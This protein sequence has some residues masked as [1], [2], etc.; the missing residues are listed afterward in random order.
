MS[1]KQQIVD[2]V[3][4][5]LAKGT[6]VDIHLAAFIGDVKKVESFLEEGVDV[7]TKAK[8]GQTPLCLAA[9]SGQ[10]EMIRFL[11]G[12]GADVNVKAW[13]SSTEEAQGYSPLYFALTYPD[14]EVVKMLID[15]G[16][17]IKDKGPPFIESPLWMLL[18]SAM[19]RGAKVF[20]EDP[21]L[22]DIGFSDE[23]FELYKETLD[24]RTVEL[25]RRIW[26]NLRDVIKLLL[27]RGADV[28]V[29]G[30]GGETLL[31]HVASTGLID[32]VEL[33]IAHGADVN[34]R[35]EQGKTPLEVAREERHIEIVELLRK[36]GAKE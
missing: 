22:D 7:N 2:M 20:L 14:Y 8:F 3:N 35:D 16:A 10:K 21:N 27:D 1:D 11:I 36:H 12:K 23:E 32:G 19:T 26:P 9:L 4:L 29:K 13:L 24:A 30:L 15:S 31:N 6:Q 17:N 34:A 25:A 5:L 28:N 18:M 33:F